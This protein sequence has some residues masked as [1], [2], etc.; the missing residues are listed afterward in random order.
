MRNRPEW[1]VA[2]VAVVNAGATAVLLNSWGQGR[3]L[4]QGL[5]DSG[6][7]LLICDAPR[8][9]FARESQPDL[10]ALVVDPESSQQGGP[11]LRRYHRP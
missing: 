2:F 9:A 1:L 10:P 4:G 5:A 8:L 3:E 6:A 7:E 11:G